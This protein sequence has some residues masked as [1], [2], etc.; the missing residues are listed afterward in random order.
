MP[1]NALLTGLSN[2]VSL[3]MLTARSSGG[4]V[5][6][7]RTA[8]TQLD[9]LLGASPEAPR[10]EAGELAPTR[11]PRS[12]QG[13]FPD[14]VRA[15]NRGSGRQRGCSWR[16]SR[17][18]GGGYASPVRSPSRS[19]CL[20]HAHPLCISCLRSGQGS[21][22]SRH[23]WL[24]DPGSRPGFQSRPSTSSIEYTPALLPQ[25]QCAARTAPTG[26]ERVWIGGIYVDRDRT[27]A[28]VFATR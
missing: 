24:L 27:L 3:L 4:A 10:V 14:I 8:F 26:G 6:C 20:L 12:V 15:V 9:R 19:S 16:C 21:A 22:R 1:A 25:S 2:G 28:R 11:P 23:S 17:L 18:V 7:R 5:G 13:P